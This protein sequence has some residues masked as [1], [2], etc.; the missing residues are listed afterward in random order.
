MNFLFQWQLS[1]IFSNILYYW[2]SN[3]KKEI[4]TIKWA[5]QHLVYL[6]PVQPM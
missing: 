1:I 2:S 4:C 6:P 5:R 3:T